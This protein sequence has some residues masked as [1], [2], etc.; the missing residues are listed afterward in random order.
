[1][2]FSTLWIQDMLKFFLARSKKSRSFDYL[3][4]FDLCHIFCPKR[5]FISHITVGLS[6]FVCRVFQV[7]SISMVSL[8]KYM[9]VLLVLQRLLCLSLEISFISRFLK[10]STP[11]LLL[12]NRLPHS[13]FIMF[14]STRLLPWL[15]E[16]GAAGEAHGG[17]KC[18]R[19]GHFATNEL[20]LCLHVL[21]HKKHVN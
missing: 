20:H 12:W 8:K 4:L 17:R 21:I 13:S 11:Y 19:R 9:N 5:V 18:E 7:L 16:Q 10:I 14:S 2:Q 6:L 3:V 1:M 15:H